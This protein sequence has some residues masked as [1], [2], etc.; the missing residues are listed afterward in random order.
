[1]IFKRFQQKKVSNKDVIRFVITLL[2]QSNVKYNIVLEYLHDI[3]I[4]FE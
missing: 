3:L 4:V 1:M 2:A